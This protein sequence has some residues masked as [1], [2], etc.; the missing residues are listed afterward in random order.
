MRIKTTTLKRIIKEEYDNVILKE[1]MNLLH[2]KQ[3]NKLAKAQKELNLIKKDPKAYIQQ[4][5]AK[6]Q[7]KVGK[8]KGGAGGGGGEVKDVLVTKMKD[9]AGDQKQDVQKMKQVDQLGDKV[10]AQAQKDPAQKPHMQ[11]LITADKA[12]HWMLDLVDS[13]NKKILGEFKAASKAGDMAKMKER[14]DYYVKFGNFSE[15][16]IDEAFEAMKKGKEDPKQYDE[17]I[18]MAKKYGFES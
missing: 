7:K 12:V 13:I 17:V 11:K 10:V 1:K 9:E 18:A 16:F 15:K 5:T 2:E 6:L 14:Y 3:G 4:R 8:G